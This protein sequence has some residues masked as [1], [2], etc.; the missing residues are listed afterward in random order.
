VAFPGAYK[1][2]D[3]GIMLNIY[4][5]VVSTSHSQISRNGLAP[6]T[7]N[8][9]ANYIHLARTLCIYWLDGEKTISVLGSIEFG[10]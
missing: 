6:E 10:K 2:T 8:C 4:Y 3:P 5:P 9:L 7:N 1:A